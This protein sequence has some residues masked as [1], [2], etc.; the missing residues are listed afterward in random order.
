MHLFE[1]DL[2]KPPHTLAYLGDPPKNEEEAWDIT[3]R[4][5]QVLAEPR[6]VKVHDGG[7]RTCGLCWLYH[8]QHQRGSGCEKCPIGIAGHV[9]CRETPYIEYKNAENPDEARECAK[10]ELYFLR[11]IKKGVVE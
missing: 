11:N 8:A 1:L 5:W 2:D 7:T 6:S 3:L 9:E 4:K 10:K